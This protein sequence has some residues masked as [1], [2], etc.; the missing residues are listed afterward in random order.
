M[1]TSEIRIS[2]LCREDQL[3]DAVGALH[4]AFE[5]GG[6]EQAVVHAGTGDDGMTGGFAQ[7]TRH[8]ERAHERG[9]SSRS[10]APPGRSAPR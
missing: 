9:R 2:V 8:H 1:N 4:E 6:D 7:D 3:D 5:L 10:S